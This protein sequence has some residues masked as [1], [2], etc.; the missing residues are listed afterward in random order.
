MGGLVSVEI[1]G[2]AFHVIFDI[3]VFVQQTLIWGHSYVLAVF[4]LCSIDIER[5]ITLLNTQFV[6]KLCA[7]HCCGQSHCC[8]VSLIFIK[9]PINPMLIKRNGPTKGPLTCCPFI[10]TFPLSF[11]FLFNCMHKFRC[12]DLD[13]CKI[14]LFSQLFSLSLFHYGISFFCFYFSCFLSNSKQACPYLLTL[15]LEL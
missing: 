10:G 6:N 12:L 1:R 4:V 13:L 11:S 5:H 9:S 14:S 2:V 7:F 8:L 3:I 15:Y